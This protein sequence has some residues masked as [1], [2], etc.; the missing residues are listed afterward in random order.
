MPPLPKIE[1]HLH[2][3]CSLSYRVVSRLRPGTTEEE[4]RRIFVAPARCR[5][6]AEY[7]TH[8]PPAVA[9]MQSEQALRLVVADVFEQLAADNVIYAEIRFAPLLH[10]ERGLTPEKVVD[11][12]QGEVAKQIAETGIEARVIL[13]TLRHFPGEYSR[14]TAQLLATFRG[15]TAVALDIAGDEAAFPLAPHQPAYQYAHDHGFFVTAHAGEGAGPASV[16]ETLR[17]LKT[18]RIGHG[19]RS[20]EDPE[21]L[22]HLKQH[23][24]HLEVC[25]TSNVQT[26]VCQSIQDHPIDRLH[27]SGVSLGINTDC[28]TISTTNLNQEYRQLEETFGWGAEEWWKC[29]RQALSAAFLPEDVRRRLEQ[30]LDAAYSNHARVTQPAACATRTASPGRE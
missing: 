29:N 28:R 6:L 17:L 7:L 9:L 24:V 3:D 13:C 16:W 1:L 21:L 4:F 10:L 23:N 8:S 30:R 5:D 2:L 14:Q 12:V 11:A 20:A 22:S 18:P 15:S 19:I 26:S 25:P 27:R